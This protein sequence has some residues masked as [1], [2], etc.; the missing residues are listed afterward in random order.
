MSEYLTKKLTDKEQEIFNDIKEW[1]PIILLEVDI[2]CHAVCHSL[3]RRH[4]PNLVHQRGT[5]GSFHQH[6]WLYFKDNP[7]LI[8]DAYPVAAIGGPLLL[9]LGNDLILKTP[10]KYMYLPKE[11]ICSLDFVNEHDGNWYPCPGKLKNNICPHAMR[12]MNE[13]IRDRRIMKYATSN[14]TKTNVN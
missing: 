8:I 7:T 4:S 2:T 5:F 3:E 6:S 11:D 12:H 13:P 9:D 10:W 14:L 1:T